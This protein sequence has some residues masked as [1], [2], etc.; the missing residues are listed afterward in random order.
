MVRQKQYRLFRMIDKFRG[1]IRLIERDESH[2][3]LAGNVFRGNDSEF[4]P[5][6]SVF[7]INPKNASARHGAANRDAVQHVRK[8]Q[9][10]DVL[11]LAGD[12]VPSFFSRH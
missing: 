6:N 11:R 3:I 4:V 12:F 10:I 2:G 1:Q 7:E 8:F 9:V 5:G